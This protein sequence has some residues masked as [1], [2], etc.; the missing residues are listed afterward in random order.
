MSVTDER[1]V[2]LAVYNKHKINEYSPE[3]QLIRE[4]NLLL[5]SHIRFPSHALK[6][7]NGH[8]VVSHGLGCDIMDRVCIVDAD[9]KLM[10]SFREKRR[11]KGGHRTLPVHLSIDGSGSVLVVDQM[12]SRVLLLDSQLEF[13]REVL[14]KEKH[15]LRNPSRILMDDS[16]SQMLLADSK[17]NSGGRIL[18]FQFC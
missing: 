14:S 8:F 11:P 6:L 1:N 4:I 3:G 15:T 5:N 13:K 18:K 9:G 7:A 17:W 10:K 2:I 12:N 16:C